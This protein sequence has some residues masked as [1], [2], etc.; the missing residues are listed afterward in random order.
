VRVG[1]VEV[2]LAVRA[3]ATGP[4]LGR[5]VGVALLAAS[6]TGARGFAEA[7]DLRDV[8]ESGEVTDVRAAE[9]A[10]GVARVA[11]DDDTEGLA[12]V[13]TVP[14]LTGGA[15]EARRFGAPVGGAGE[16][17]TAGAA[18]GA[19][20]LAVVALTVLLTAVVAAVGG[21]EAAEAPGAALVVA[22]GAARVAAGPNVPELIT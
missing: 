2:L 13:P 6:V 18:I 9:A 20:G 21:L 8:T 4:K 14:C 12:T 10:V 15:S 11:V 3:A 1:L 22:G 5:D 17:A 7:E 19:L 16:R